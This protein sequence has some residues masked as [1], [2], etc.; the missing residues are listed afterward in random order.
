M[1]YT[2]TVIYTSFASSVL[3]HLY[4]WFIWRIVYSFDALLLP[5]GMNEKAYYLIRC[6]DVDDWCVEDVVIAH[7]ERVWRS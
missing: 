4:T 5:R 7:L 3:L 2:R 6:F 1:H